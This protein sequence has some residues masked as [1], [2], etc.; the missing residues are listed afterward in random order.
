MQVGFEPVVMPSHVEEVVKSREPD[1]VVR[2]LSSRKA[3][4]VAGRWMA[5]ERLEVDGEGVEGLYDGREKEK[6]GKKEKE[7]ENPF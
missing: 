1:V 7:K 5:G 6:P 3:E 2:D 4:D